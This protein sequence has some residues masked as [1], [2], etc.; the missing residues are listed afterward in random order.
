MIGHRHF[1]SLE[2]EVGAVV[3]H[4]AHRGV[5]EESEE[6]AADENHYEAVE[7]DFAEHKGPV[8]GEDLT[9]ERLHRC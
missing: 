6:R 7:R 8:V 4:H 5:V 3:L 9:A 2:G 1:N